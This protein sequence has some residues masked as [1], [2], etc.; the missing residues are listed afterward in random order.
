MINE[1]VSEL[2]NQRSVAINSCV[3]HSSFIHVK[4]SLFTCICSLTRIL[5]FIKLR[6]FAPNPEDLLLQKTHNPLKRKIDV[7][8]GIDDSYTADFLDRFKE[9]LRPDSWVQTPTRNA[10]EYADALAFS[11]V[12]SSSIN[13]TQAGLHGASH[14]E[15]MRFLT[16]RR[17]NGMPPPLKLWDKF[18]RRSAR[19]TFGSLCSRSCLRSTLETT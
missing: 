9:P 2:P 18:A 15:H 11:I 14:T 5:H 19:K 16:T 12:G 17:L 7:P 13:T 8:D 3:Y 1:A 4:L 6:T 10:R